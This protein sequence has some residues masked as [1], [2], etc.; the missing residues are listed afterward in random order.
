MELGSCK[1]DGEQG[2]PQPL[3]ENP[4]R[5]LVNKKNSIFYVLEAK[6]HLRRLIPEREE[7]EGHFLLGK[8]FQKLIIVRK[9]R[10][11]ALPIS[12]VHSNLK[13][14]SIILVKETNFHFH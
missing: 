13:E 5:L 1:W 9:G 11:R 3:V 14:I 10:W 6:D 2:Q 4:T 12:P 7:I 8:C